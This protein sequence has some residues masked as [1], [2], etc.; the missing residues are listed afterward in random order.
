[1]LKIFNSCHTWLLCVAFDQLQVKKQL[2]FKFIIKK[3]PFFFLILNNT[4]LFLFLGTSAM[5]GWQGL[6]RF[7]KDK[8]VTIKDK[9]VTIKDKSVTLTK[10]NP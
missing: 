5:H 7:K 8:S 4:F 10:T 6:Q 9:S 2:K 3:M 1:M